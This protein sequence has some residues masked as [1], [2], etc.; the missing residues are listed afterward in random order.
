MKSKGFKLKWKILERRIQVKEPD[1]DRSKDIS[2]II[3]R[4]NRKEDG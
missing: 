1:L 3:K 4:E 2:L